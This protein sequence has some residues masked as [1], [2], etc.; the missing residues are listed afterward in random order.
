MNRISLALTSLVAAIPGGFMA[1]LCI[2]A[3]LSYTENMPTMLSVVNGVTLLV[4]VLL[5]LLPFAI[6]LFIKGKPK[7][8]AVAGADAANGAA[9]VAGTK[10]G[11]APMKG[12]SDDDDAI[13]MDEM[14]EMNDDELADDD[15]E[16][17]VA[18]DAFGD[19]ATISEATA[20]DAGSDDAF[21]FDDDDK[22]DDD[23]EF[24]DDDD[25]LK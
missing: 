24:D 2:K 3:F 13:E 17:D 6:L 12:R 1:Y 8:V 20:D 10:S 23:F 19:D 21:E 16:E 5:A 11:S 18:D 25:K 15:M 9:E 4:C 14:D 7:E 22:D